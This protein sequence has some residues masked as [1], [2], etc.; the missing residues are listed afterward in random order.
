MSVARESPR[1]APERRPSPMWK[2]TIAGHDVP[3]RWRVPAWTV[4]LGASTGDA[5]CAQV[6]RWAHRD[7]GVAP[8]RSLLAVSLAHAH[9]ERSQVTA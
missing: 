9:A 5:A 8:L 1:R 3:P 7:A 6:V 2:V 4:T